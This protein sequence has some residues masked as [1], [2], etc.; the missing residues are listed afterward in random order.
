M[1]VFTIDLYVGYKFLPDNA[2]RDAQAADYAITMGRLEACRIARS[3]GVDGPHR[4]V[5]RAYGL[6]RAEEG[7][8]LAEFMTTDTIEIDAA[9]SSITKRLGSAVAL[10]AILRVPQAQPQDLPP[11][12][13]R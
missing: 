2:G 13:A 7:V 12:N 10:K 1:A 3:L 11:D 4:I 8:V 9:N 5:V 6:G